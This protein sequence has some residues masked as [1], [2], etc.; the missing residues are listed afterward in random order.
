MTRCGNTWCSRCGLQ[1][2]LSRNT[3]TLVASIA[4]CRT[5]LRPAV[6]SIGRPLLQRA[7]PSC[8]SEQLFF[9]R[10]SIG[11]ARHGKNL[12]PPR[13]G[14][15]TFNK[16]HFQERGG[17][18]GG[19]FHTK[20]ST[21]FFYQELHGEKKNATR[22]NYIFFQPSQKNIY[23]LFDFFGV[24]FDLLRMPKKSFITHVCLS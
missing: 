12:K 3:K 8:I 2:F 11:S 17:E 13:I 1:A 7:L 15:S 9:A 23:F 5:V 16:R 6:S 24:V 21:F 4:C 14:Y 20:I 22:T 19:G 18:R 10:Q